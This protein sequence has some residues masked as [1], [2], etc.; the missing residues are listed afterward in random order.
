[1]FLNCSMFGL[2]IYRRL[3]EVDLNALLCVGIVL[4][5]IQEPDY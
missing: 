2:G 5:S 3:S 1:M 4:V